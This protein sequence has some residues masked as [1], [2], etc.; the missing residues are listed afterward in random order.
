MLSHGCNT[1]ICRHL[2]IIGIDKIWN[3]HWLISNWCLIFRSFYCNVFF[4][5]HRLT[6]WF[7]GKL[8]K[9]I[10]WLIFA[11]KLLLGLIIGN[12]WFCLEWWS[13]DWA[14]IFCSLPQR[15]A[16]FSY[17]A[18]AFGRFWCQ[19]LCSLYWLLLLEDTV[20]RADHYW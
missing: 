20:L 17:I 8:I 14:T 19:R 9:E 2:T 13:F 18:M 12:G 1:D 16:V 15:H 6:I 10:M 5:H 11:S 4:K 3:A 7:L